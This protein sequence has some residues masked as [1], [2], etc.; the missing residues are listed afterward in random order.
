VRGTSKFDEAARENM[1]AKKNNKG[2]KSPAA[3]TSAT[4]VVDTIT[5]GS[6]PKAPPP[7][8]RA[9]RTLFCPSLVP[10]SPLLMPPT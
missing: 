3:K 2:K 1:G 8:A 5:E 9:A 4:K 6:S 10:C 7:L